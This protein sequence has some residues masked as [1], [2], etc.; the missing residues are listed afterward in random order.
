VYWACA[1]LETHRERLALHCLGVAGF[2][3][4]MPRL[5]VKRVTRT[6]KM[7]MLMPALFPNYCFVLIELQWHAARW[8][9]GVIRLVL[10]GIQPAKVPDAVIDGIRS[11]E[12]NGLVELPSAPSAPGLKRGERVIVRAGP[13]QD[14]LGLYDGQA[15]HQRV[16]VLL[17][18]LGSQRRVELRA[19][20]VVSVGSN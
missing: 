11:R 18:W 17:M 10:D 6:R 14:H 12:R 19:G 7:S 1:Q 2:Q 20:D 13:F 16:A 4:Y 5:R 8:C 9:P 3:T 15:P